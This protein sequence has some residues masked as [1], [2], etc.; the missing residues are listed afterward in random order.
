MAN[1]PLPPLFLADHPALDFLN[2]IASPQGEPIDWLD[3]GEKL[4][5]WLVQSGLLATEIA[6]KFTHADGLDEVASVA[7][8]LRE[9]WRSFITSHFNRPLIAED[10]KGLQRLNALLAQDCT[11]DRIETISTGGF[12]RT[13]HRRWKTPEQLLQVFALVIAD[14]L[15]QVDFSLVRKCEN[16]DCTLIFHDTTKS[17]RRRWCSMAVCGN[18][19]KA[20][21]HR[22]RTKQ[23]A[24][25][26][27]TSL[28]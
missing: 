21:A 1:T 17:H 22:A 3:D 7:R 26:T 13:Q 14:C 19:A 28:R 4:L 9:W 8:E 6:Q 18:R 10:L 2:S 11:Y 15:C 5:N 23:S 24:G 25:D 27:S 16:P 20:A 12:V